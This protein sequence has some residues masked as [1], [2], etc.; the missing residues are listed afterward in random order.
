MPTTPENKAD[1]RNAATPAQPV[2]PIEEA[3]GPDAAALPAVPLKNAQPRTRRAFEPLTGAFKVSGMRYAAADIAGVSDQILTHEIPPVR[4]RTLARF[5]DA[6]AAPL[7]NLDAATRT[8]DHPAP[9][10]APASMTGSLKTLDAPTLSGGFSGHSLQADNTMT[11]GLGAKLAGGDAPTIQ[12][13]ML[14]DGLKRSGMHA[15]SQKPSAK[16]VTAAAKKDAEV[17]NVGDVIDG[18]YEVLDI[19]GQGGMG[20]VYRIRHRE[21]NLEMA[22]KTPL[23]AL[24]NHASAKARFLREA[25][26]WVDLGLHP[27]LVQCWFVRELGGLPRVF[28]DYLSGGSLK[29]WFMDG[30]VKPGEYDKI[31][32][33]MA[34]ACDGLGYAHDRGV[35]HRDIKPGNMLMTEDGRLCVTDFGLVKLAGVEDISGGPPHSSG[36]QAPARQSSAELT[37]AGG[38]LGTPQYGAPEQWGGARDVDARAD[39]YALGIT[40]YE[41]CCGRRPF[42]QPGQR[43]PAQVIIARQIGSMPPDP[44]TFCQRLPD[45]LAVLILKCLA[46]APKDRPSSLLEVREELQAAHFAIY[47]YPLARAVPEAAESR[48]SGLNNRAVSMW[49]LGQPA[50]A[51]A[52]WQEALALDPRHAESIYNSSL[53]DF[54]LGK[55]TDYD[56]EQRLREAAK[57]QRKAHVYLGNLRLETCDA[58]GAQ[59]NFEEALKEPALKGD[60]FVWRALGHA[61]M[62]QEQFREA[63]EAYL[64]ALEIL[65][66]DGDARRGAELARRHVRAMGGRNAYPLIGPHHALDERVGSIR[67]LAAAPDGRSIYCDG[68]LNA[69]S[70]FEIP[71][72]KL[73]GTFEGSARQ[74]LSIAASPDGKFVL[75]GGEDSQLR[76]WHADSRLPFEDFYGKGHIGSILAIAITPDS[77]MA[78]TAGGDKSVRIWELAKGGLV[79]SL[80]GH[81]EAV[82][83]VA[84]SPCGGVIASGSL[85]GTVRFWDSATHA[86]LAE[87]RE[88][89]TPV[90]ALAFSADGAFI[91]SAGSDGVVLKWDCATLKPVCV[92]NGHRGT[93]NALGVVKN[94]GGR[95]LVSCGDDSTIRVWDTTSGCCLRTIQGHKGA[96]LALA[97]P[98]RMA[99]LVSGGNE[100]LGQP[101]R[102]WHFELE[103]FL[104]EPGDGD[105]YAA[106]LS[107]CRIEK[108]EQSQSTS[109]RFNDCMSKATGEFMSENFAACYLTLC[110]A[111]TIEGYER[112]PRALE[113]NARLAKKLPL[114]GVAAFYPRTEIEGR[115]AQG[116]KAVLCSKD[117]KAAFSAGRNDKSIQIWDLETGVCARKLEGHKQAVEGLAL[118]PH[119]QAGQALLVSASSDYSVGIWD[120]AAGVLKASLQ[121]HTREVHAVAVSRDGRL[122]ASASSDATLRIWEVGSGKCVKVFERENSEEAFVAVKFMPDGR[123]IVA[124]GADG[125]L[126]HF[127]LATGRVLVEFPGHF[128][129]IQDLA[130]L[131]DKPCFIS[132]GEDKTMRCWN[133]D[134]GECVWKVMDGKSRFHALA[135]SP[136]QQFIFSGGMEQHETQ[137]K[138]WDTAT[139]QPRGVFCP[140]AKGIAAL[141][142]SEDGMLLLTGSG[143]KYLRVFEIEWALT[144]ANPKSA[145][146]Q[147]A[148]SPP[149][150]QPSLA[151]RRLSIFLGGK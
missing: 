11:G 68:A 119:T 99:M 86:S 85:D 35:V 46:K 14:P 88:A 9:G 140:H 10:S 122:A 39:I 144:A 113:L 66:L 127:S 74:I 136:D 49:D 8:F 104:R 25:Q 151:Q 128:G 93:V 60:G 112:D 6:P 65:P 80:W 135:F 44:R 7:T 50:Q 115:H 148:A 76:A 55:I 142:L 32:D 103:R 54:R 70:Q 90:R 75:N 26:F 146:V 23:P 53:I 117:G 3:R 121:G 24:V 91:F 120:V 56:A 47:G 71:T 33:L 63:E 107:V 38:S 130:M 143:D 27:N 124:G 145:L 1:D 51:A 123:H 36:T 141:A 59:K 110:E 101:L 150:A 19:A 139:G 20:V 57:L 108:V 83:A 69:M 40:L 30:R 137:V 92:F 16:S 62:S 48:A 132:A 77:R 109:R 12:A 5:D 98:E 72:G 18:K 89:L 43:E 13:G 73:L 125:Y 111:R 58:P 28:V 134:K 2:P 147:A 34:Q 114:R 31:I 97:L 102:L 149:A 95:L 82:H 37:Q 52:A 129:A 21:W 100:N 96:V 79:K 29:D 22:V 131:K 118:V 133:V 94:A 67:A 4:R 41:L 15:R 138:L 45:C 78:A 106:A 126:A 61:R 116:F 84:I 87:L 64:K 17:W 105:P 81:G 42:D